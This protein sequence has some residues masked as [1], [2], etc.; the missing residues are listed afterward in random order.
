MEPLTRT[1]RVVTTNSV[2]VQQLAD[3]AGRTFPLACPAS[4]A[5][6]NIAA[7]VKANLTPARFAEYLAD[8]RR[9]VMTAES[10]ERIIGYAML[11]RDGEAAELSKIYVA[12]EHHGTGVATALMDLALTTAGEWKVSRVWL[13]VN[14]ANQRAQRF[15]AKSGFQVSGTRTFQVGAG[16]ENDF[17]M[18][19][20][21]P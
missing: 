20:P 18:T 10:G 1:A 7:F 2:D 16:R 9:A 4:M 13:G 11:I 14:Q 5:P 12:P 21:L 8:P 6:E 15:Y 19:R 3:V 17:V